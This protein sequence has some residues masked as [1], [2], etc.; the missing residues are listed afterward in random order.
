MDPDYR[1]G[2]LNEGHESGMEIPS[3]QEE[4]I[5]SILVDAFDVT[6]PPRRLIL[7]CFRFLCTIL[8]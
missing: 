6:G 4:G 8:F 2:S 7:L 5:A 3:R 1:R